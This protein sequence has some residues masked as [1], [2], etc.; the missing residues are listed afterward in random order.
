MV[1]RGDMEEENRLL[2]FNSDIL[3]LSL[4][5]SFTFSNPVPLVSPPLISFPALLLC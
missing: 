1:E 2:T 3:N 4:S 5:L